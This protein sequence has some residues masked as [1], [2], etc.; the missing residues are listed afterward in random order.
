M[1]AYHFDEIID[2]Q[3]TNSINAGSY[4]EFLLGGAKLP[5]KEEEIIRMWVADMEFAVPEVIL[6]AIR[7]RVDRRIFGYTKILDPGY[8]EAFEAWNRNRY[9]WTFPKDHLVTSPGIV[10][11]LFQLPAMMTEPDE[12]ILI[13]TPSYAPFKGAADFNGREAVYSALISEDQHWSM[14]LED[15]RRKA[16]DPKTT[17]CIFC[18]P[19]NPTGRSWSREELEAFS[20]IMR[21]ENMWVISDEIHCDL[22]RSGRRHIPLGSVLGD[23]TRLVTCMAP[24][25]TFNLAGMMISNLII[26]DETLRSEWTQKNLTGE[27]PLSIAAAQAAYGQGEDWLKALQ[28]YLDDNFRFVKAF[29]DEHLPLTRF[30]IPEATYLAWVDLSAYL[31][32]DLES[33][34]LFFAEKA[35]VI[36]ED[37]R[38]F[39]DNADGHVRL[40]LAC[41]RAVLEKGLA[42]IHQALTSDH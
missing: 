28:L 16:A 11:A 38:M 15:L 24:T 8:Y 6:D 18:N 7:R 20:E 35:G 1:Q 30:R 14:D 13:M 41:P 9:G 36:L 25:K 40:N 42:R 21:N 19:H 22:L 32:G 31:P 33:I 29:L 2:R 34:P 23:Y 12:K 3:G 5:W 37:G 17:L 4:R 10:P 39:V 27:N 26:P